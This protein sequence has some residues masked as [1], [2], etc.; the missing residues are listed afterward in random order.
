MVLLN[1]SFFHFT[2]TFCG[3]DKSLFN[4]RFLVFVL[5]FHDRIYIL[6]VSVSCTSIL[7]RDNTLYSD[8][9]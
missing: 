3:S 2:I 7:T 8:Y 1:S 4:L 9:D 5:I 6:C